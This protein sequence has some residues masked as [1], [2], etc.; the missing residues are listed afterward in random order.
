M[1]S[2][3]LPSVTVGSLSLVYNTIVGNPVTPYLPAISGAV[4]ASSLASFKPADARTHAQLP[5]SK[6]LLAWRETH[7]TSYNPSPAGP[8]PVRTPARGACSGRTM[9]CDA[10]PKIKSVYTAPTVEPTVRGR[11]RQREEGAHA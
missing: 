6:H 5:A 11:R 2:P 9:A 4:V 1:S 3:V 7:V 10:L 8:P